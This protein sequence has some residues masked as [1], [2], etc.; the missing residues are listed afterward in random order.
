MTDAVIAIRD[1]EYN[2][3]ASGGSIIGLKTSWVSKYDLQNV[4]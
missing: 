4:G 1:T 2:T 3:N